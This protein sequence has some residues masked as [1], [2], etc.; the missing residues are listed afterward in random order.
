MINGFYDCAKLLLDYGA[1]P[2]AIYFNGS[3]LN[4]LAERNGN[5]K[6]IELLLKYGANP[7]FRLVS[8]N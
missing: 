8:I 7:N 3:E 1:N 5:S 4:L 2:N 6:Y